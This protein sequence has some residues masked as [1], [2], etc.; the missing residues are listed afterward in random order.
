MPSPPAAEPEAVNPAPG[1][2][3]FPSATLLPA[4]PFQTI[5][6][7]LAK[8]PEALSIPS[9]MV[10]TKVGKCPKGKKRS[11]GKCVKVKA[12]S[13]HSKGQKRR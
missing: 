4:I 5:A 6:E 11:H 12:K 1:P 3:P 8:E 10:P 2:S 13:K 9:K 7:L